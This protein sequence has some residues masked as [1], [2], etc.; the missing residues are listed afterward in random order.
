LINNSESDGFGPIITVH[1]CFG[2][3]PNK[4]DELVY[5]VKKEFIL[6]Y[7]QENFLTNER[8]IQSI[9]DNH[10]EIIFDEQAKRQYILVNEEFIKIPLVPK[11][12]FI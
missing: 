2:T 11:I 8:L 5:R 6:L 9:L 12:L 3:H 7:S 10:F 1:D 4:K